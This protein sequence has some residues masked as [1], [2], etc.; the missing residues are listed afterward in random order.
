M[1]V[2]LAAAYAEVGEFDKAVESQQAVIDLLPA[3][4]RGDY[5]SR[6]ELYRQGIPHRQPA[7]R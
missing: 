3:G 5:Q 4:Q 6:L 2:V 7:A 1:L